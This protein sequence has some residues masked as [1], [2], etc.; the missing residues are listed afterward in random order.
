MP[1]FIRHYGMDI[2]TYIL[3]RNLWL[4]SNLIPKRFCSSLSYNIL[5]ASHTSPPTNVNSGKTSDEDIFHIN[6]NLDR[7]IRLMKYLVIKVDLFSSKIIVITMIY[8]RIMS[9]EPEWGQ[10][11]M[12][13]V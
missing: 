1:N 8:F 11:H 12:L 5:K 7:G 3:C 10:G 4:I 13:L 9:W 2:M 6:P